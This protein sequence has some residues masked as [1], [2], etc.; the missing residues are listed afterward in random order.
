VCNIQ[1][2]GDEMKKSILLILVG[3]RKEEAVKVQ[4]ILTGWGCM[5]KTR[6]GIHDGVLDNCSDSGLVILE[7]VGEDEKKQELARKLSVLPG[8]SSKLIDLE[9]E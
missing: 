1:P 6:L 9:V 8:V 5:I 7:L 3:K 4:Q 2:S